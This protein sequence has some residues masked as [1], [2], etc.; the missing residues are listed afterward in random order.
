MLKVGKEKIALICIV[1]L[2]FVTRFYQLG[3]VPKGITWDE[4]AIGYTGFSIL[5]TRRDEWLERL[6]VSFKSF[7]DYKAPLA[8]YLNSPFT[9]LFGVN[10]FAVRMPFALAGIASVIIFYHLIILLFKDKNAIYFGLI[11]AFSFATTPWHVHFSRIG[12]ESGIAL[13]FLL[14]SVYFIIKLLFDESI[15]NRY[16]YLYSIIS[17]VFFACS[18]YTY[19]SAKLVA[20]LLI[21]SI[22]IC[23]IKKVKHTF[24]AICLFSFTT[25][26]LLI[27]LIKDS[28]WGHGLERAGVSIFSSL[29]FFD[30]VFTTVKQFF[31]HLSPQFL[32]LGQTNDLRHGDGVWG[33][34]TI[35]QY[36]FVILGFIFG[37]KNVFYSKEQNKNVFLLALLWVIV[38]I[39]PAAISQDVPHSNRALLALPGFMLLSLYGLQQ[40]CMY[41]QKITGL[42]GKKQKKDIYLKLVLGMSLFFQMFFFISYIH[43]Y[44]AVYKITSADAFS[45]GYIEAFTIAK[46]YEKGQNGKQEVDKILFTSE[47]GQPYI[48][49]LF[50]RKTN[51]IWYQGGSLVKYEFTDKINS[52]DLERSNTLI[53]AG[54]TSNLDTSKAFHTINDAAGNTRFSFYLT[55]PKQ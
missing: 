3:T 34:L 19:H 33:V 10:A 4:A 32:I 31:L 20:P 24:K 28:I 44:F 49:A 1:L 11:G 47:Y 29:P 46:E 27:P 22:L 23:N 18:M 36:I 25:I 13:L 40:L 2:A 41:I 14:I 38:G 16:S 54:K 30:A 9:F 21:G 52:G 48:Y 39:L 37:L 26:L 17:S 15:K 5:T 7:G 51:P 12:F 45:E 6:P 53:V 8:I 43:D 35:I 42:V 55:K 50:V